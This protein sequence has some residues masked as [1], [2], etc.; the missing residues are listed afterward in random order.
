MCHT[1]ATDKGDERSQTRKL[2]RQSEANGH[3]GVSHSPGVVRVGRRPEPWLWPQSG[4][5]GHRL[6][7]GSGVLQTRLL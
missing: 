2:P 6:R 7:V 3:T 4:G 5:S 1:R